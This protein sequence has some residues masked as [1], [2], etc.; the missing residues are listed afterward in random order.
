LNSAFASGWNGNTPSRGNS[1]F[2][3]A[4]YLADP[5]QQNSY[6]PMRERMQ[7]RLC[8][9]VDFAGKRQFLLDLL[10]PIIFDNDA[11][12]ATVS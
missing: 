1:T 10:E 5:Q 3:W 8:R 11:Y 6:N 9:I 4:K 12:T 2:S 7:E